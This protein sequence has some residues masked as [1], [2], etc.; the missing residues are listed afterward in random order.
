MLKKALWLLLIT[1]LMWSSTPN[2][3]FLD[4]DHVNASQDP[5]TFNLGP[6]KEASVTGI[7]Y[8]SNSSYTR[9]VI[10]LDHEVSYTDHLLKEDVA[11][12]KP[13]RIFLDLKGAK[14]SHQLAEPI[15]I[16][17]E[18]LKRARAGQYS[19]DTVRV[20]LDLESITDY[21][22]FSLSDPFRIVIDVFG[23]YSKAKGKEVAI[24]SVPR[25]SHITLVI[26]PGHGGEDPG[27]IGPKGLKEKDVVL[28]IAQKVQAKVLKE[29]GWKVI[30]TRKEDVFLPLEERTAIANT[31]GGDLFL[32]IHAN[33]SRNNRVH[34]IETYF[35]NYTTDKDALRL[36]AKESGVAPE[37][38]SDLQ[39]ILYDL[40]LNAKGN[41]S[42]Q[43]AEYIQEAMIGKLQKRYSRV[44][45][46]G[47]K[48][49]PFVVLFGAKMPSILLEVSFISNSMEERR[50]RD[51]KYLDDMANSIMEGLKKYATDTKVTKGDQPSWSSSTAFSSN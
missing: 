37:K 19:P 32:S 13:P 49:G 1:F 11:L 30:M 29:L 44:K 10:D 28:K 36:A 51:E 16:E 48:Q 7:R 6:Q 35:L 25:P 26:D 43:L 41:E 20:V 17:D 21:K 42:S 45:N 14:L 18:L 3:F 15:P 27:A 22:I 8:W 40:M 34:G 24:S 39:L 38:I 31:N 9:I 4:N 23:K 47:V 12:K 2:L 50:L 33:A 5:P 46:L